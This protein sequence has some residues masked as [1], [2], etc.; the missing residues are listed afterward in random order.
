MNVQLNSLK[1]HFWEWPNGLV[2]RCTKPITFKS[3]KKKF[4]L[5][6]KTMQ[7]TPRETIL[8]VG[9]SLF[10]GGYTNFLEKWYPYPH[11]ITA[12]TVENPDRLHDFRSS[13]PKVNLIFQDGR[14]LDFPD[15]KFDIVFSNA[16]VEHTGTRGKQRQFIHEIVRI[17]KR[18]FITTPYYYFPI[19]AHT[20]IPLAHYLPLDLRFWVYRK[21]GRGYFADLDRLNLLTAKQFRSLFP[22]NLKVFLYKPRSFGIINNL[23]A[24]VEK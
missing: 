23:I 9:V 22:P 10:S 2:W 12:L 17:G 6:M 8:D 3:R 18:A 13:F 20:L 19:D 24:V 14:A 7:P 16:V 1:K 11:M 21:C 5:F 4:D 15:N